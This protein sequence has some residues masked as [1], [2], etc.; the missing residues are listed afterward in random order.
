MTLLTQ[1]HDIDDPSGLPQLCAEPEFSELVTE[2]ARTEAPRLF[3]V[4]LEYGERVDAKIA[5]WGLAFEAR[6]DVI[7]IE[8]RLRMT[9]PGPE[10]ALRRFHTRPHVHPR[11]FWI[12]AETP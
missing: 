3:A 9:L 10:Q 7:S 6:A 1:S 2:M 5:G 8:G 12:T 4:V 11:L